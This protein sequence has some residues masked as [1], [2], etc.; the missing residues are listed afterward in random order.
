M[1]YFLMSNIVPYCTI[2]L[3]RHED[4]MLANFIESKLTNYLSMTIIV[5]TFAHTGRKS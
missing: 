5:K 4:T 1:E 3:Y 2:K